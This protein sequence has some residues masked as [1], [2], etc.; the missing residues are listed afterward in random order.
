MGNI[1]TL[2]DPVQ[3]RV[4]PLWAKVVTARSAL[5]VV[6]SLA[7]G[8]ALALD[9]LI[10]LTGPSHPSD[11]VTAPLLLLSPW[12]FLLGTLLF[13]RASPRRVGSA[14]YLLFASA[15]C[16][17]ALAPGADDDQPLA[18]AAELAAVPL[19][20]AAFA[21]FFLTF[22]TPRDVPHRRLLLAPAL[23]S[24]ALGLAALVWPP[25]DGPG[26]LLRLIILLAYLLLGVAL[27]VRS[28]ATARDRDARRG[29]RIIGAGTIASILPFVALNLLPTLLG[30][31]APVGAEQAILALAIL[32]ASFTYAILRYHALHAPLLQ[33]WLVHGL[34]WA[35][36]LA[37]YVAA[38]STLQTLLAVVL[39][40]PDRS[41][42]FTIALV[43]LVGVSF[44]WLRDR[45]ARCLDRLLFKDAYD[46]RAALQGLS[47]DLSLAGNLGVPGASFAHALRTLMNLDF[48][49]LFARD[50]HGALSLRDADGEAD[51]SAVLAWIIHE[52]A[53]RGPVR[54]GRVI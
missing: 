40:A 7:Y 28:W 12:F 4:V 24:I 18:V 14:A 45:L 20:A 48:A 37:L 53:A 34:L 47:R 30:Q 38:A 26:G 51:Q 1:A 3:P 44:Q 33:R 29:L 41:L 11:R 17:L 43:V 50:S 23:V 46:Y 6:G 52:V 25:L 31:P 54:Y 22:P 49:L 2:A 10:L 39:P 16:A 19:F 21:H 8:T 13:M 32:P 36:L 9:G 27:L 15:A 35:C 42:A 5:V